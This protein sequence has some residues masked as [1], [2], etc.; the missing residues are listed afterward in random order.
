MFARA[1]DV[2]LAGGNAIIFLGNAARLEE[3]GRVVE[4]LALEK[5][6]RIFARQRRR[7]QALGVMRR[8]GVE[9]LEP[10]NMGD[11]RRPI[12]RMLGAVFAA[13]RAAQHN[14]HLQLAR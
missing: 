4:P 14:G 6:H 11:Q 13:N 2:G 8:G 1:F 9:N 3:F 12:L 7:H 10:G 5:D